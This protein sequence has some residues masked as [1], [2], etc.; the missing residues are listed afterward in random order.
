[1]IPLFMPSG[2]NVDLYNKFDDQT[3][4]AIT[5]SFG[6]GVSFAV[7]T[8]LRADQQAYIESVMKVRDELG[9]EGTIL[10]PS[11]ALYQEICKM[12]LVKTL[13]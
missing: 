13:I 5:A 10:K 4:Q 1:M 7:K 9:K 12:L 11:D 8:E 2:M 6:A 3:K